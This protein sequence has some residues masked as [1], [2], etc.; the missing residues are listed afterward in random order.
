M[1][2]AR[3]HCCDDFSRPKQN[4]RRA[5]SN[6]N[7]DFRPAPTKCGVSAKG[8]GDTTGFGLAT[9]GVPVERRR[10]NAIYPDERRDVDGGLEV[11]DHCTIGFRRD[12]R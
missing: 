6:E 10:I 3:R 5:P 4:E 8:L 9:G 1:Y 7:R 2:D 11:S 12:G